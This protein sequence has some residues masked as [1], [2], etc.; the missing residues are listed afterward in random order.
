LTGW[1]WS[2]LIRRTLIWISWCFYYFSFH[3]KY[4]EE[5]NM[6]IQMS[7]GVSMSLFH[8]YCQVSD[9]LCLL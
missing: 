1:D 6:D 8:T 9:N 5:V 3:I 2:H 7:M 4:I